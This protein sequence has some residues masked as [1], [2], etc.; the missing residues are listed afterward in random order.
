MAEIKL[1]RP[2]KSEDDKLAAK[3][4]LSFTN[5]E[6]DGLYKKASLAGVKPATYLRQLVLGLREGI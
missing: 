5:A 3:I 4:T 1:G 2:V 6:A